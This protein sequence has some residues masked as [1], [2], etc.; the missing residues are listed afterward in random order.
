MKWIAALTLV[1]L[2]AGCGYAD[3]AMQGARPTPSDAV[4]KPGTECVIT[5]ILDPQ[6]YEEYIR[7][8]QPAYR[9]VLDTLRGLQ[10]AVDTY[11]TINV[12]RTNQLSSER[13]LV[14]VYFRLN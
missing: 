11:C 8:S 2:L 4:V 5:A 3:A 9:D 12:S 1:P 10:D 14:S 7:G 13:A 6:L